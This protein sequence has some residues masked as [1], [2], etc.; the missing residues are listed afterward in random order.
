MLPMQA[1]TAQR[2]AKVIAKQALKLAAVVTPA[3]G[4][5]PAK[6]KAP[7]AARE[8]TQKHARSESIADVDVPEPKRL[9]QGV[10]QVF[11]DLDQPFTRE[12]INEIEAQTLRATVSAGV[13]FRVWD[14]REVLKLFGLMRSCPPEIMPS[15]KVVAGRLLDDAAEKVEVQVKHALQG[16]EVGLWYV[17]IISRK[18][19]S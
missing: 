17:F 12:E 13:P 7:A 10:F 2:N 4:P 5:G 11:S 8:S 16:R 3:S 15:S 19:F 18:S 6:L 9:K 1:A 14:N